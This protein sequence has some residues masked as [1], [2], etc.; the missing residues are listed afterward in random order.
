LLG[1]VWWLW[2][3]CSTGTVQ[4]GA[5]PPTPAATASP[6]VSTEEKKETPGTSTPAAAAPA[7]ETPAAATPAAE[8]PAAGAAS[9]EATAN[10]TPSP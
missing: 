4:P 5:N 9:P 1:L 3:S 6:T 2:R 10:A 7:A 8:T